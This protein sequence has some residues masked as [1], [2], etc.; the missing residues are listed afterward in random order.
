MW[1]A[2]G[3][4]GSWNI[5]AATSSDGWNWDTL[6][7]IDTTQIETPQ[8]PRCALQAAPTS[9]FRIESAQSGQLPIDI[10]PAYAFMAYEDGWSASA[11]AGYWLGPSDAGAYSKGGIRIDS[12]DPSAHMAWL[13]ITDTGGTPRIGI[14]D[15][16]DGQPIARDAVVLDTGSGFDVDGVSSPV[17]WSRDDSTLVMAYGGHQGEMITIGSATSIDGITW[18]REDQLLVNG[19]D[20]NSQAME[21]SHMEVT[22]EG[23]R[24][25]YSGTDGA[26]WRIGYATSTDGYTWTNS[27]EPVFET[28]KPGDWDD[29]GVR[30]PWIISGTQD[31]MSGNHMWYSGFDGATWRIGHAFLPTDGTSWIRSENTV[32]GITRPVVDTVDSLFHP[33]GVLRPVVIDTEYGWEMWFAGLYN[34]VERVG[35]AVGEDAERLVRTP[36]WPTNGDTLTFQTQRGDA[37]IHAIPLDTNIVGATLTGEGLTAIDLDEER[38]FL[39]ASSKLLP[40]ITVIDIR[41]DSIPGKFEDLNYLDIEAVLLANTFS[42]GSG[43]RQVIPVAGSDVL[44]ALNDAP[45][46]VMLLDATT[47]IDDEYA[48]LIYDPQIGWLPTPVSNRDEGANT[49]TPIGPAQMVLHPDGL[50]LVTNFNANS[51]SVYDLNLGP[52]GTMVAEIDGVGENPYAITLTPDG[53]HAVFANYSGEVSDTGLTESSLGILDL[54]PASATYLTVVT[55]IS[56]Q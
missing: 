33:D 20:W 4:P 36:K 12:V 2:D 17:V 40:Y 34:D 46:S 24:L 32:T 39:Y 48:D 50:L 9:T 8:P 43:F 19:D 25:W 54:D 18:T 47:L 38:G 45:E 22:E 5:H 44:Y 37:D 31:G 15:F 23:W 13:T 28:G 56:N 52:Y 30:D 6:D 35:H 3:E 11:V 1:Y 27:T 42:V 49:Q 21:P 26:S 29:S 53:R 14:A 16:F 10:P 41:D 7:A 51:I 55:W